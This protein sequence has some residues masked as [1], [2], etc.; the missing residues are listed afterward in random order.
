MSISQGH[1]AVSHLRILLA[2]IL[3][4]ITLF[5]LGF[6]ICASPVTTHVLSE[7]TSLFDS[8]LYDHDELVGLADATR[9][10]TVQVHFEGWQAAQDSMCKKIVKA[11]QESADPQSPKFFR[12]T[13]MEW[14]TRLSHVDTT[15]TEQCVQTISEMT[16]ISD[17]YALDD[18]AFAH[19][20]D[21]NMLIS[22]VYVV[23]LFIYGV[24]VY[25]LIRAYR[26]NK[27][28]FVQ[29]LHISSWVCLASII[30]LG[31]ACLIDFDSF[32]QTFHA[33]FFPEGNWTFSAHSL[34]ISM[35][36]SAFWMGMGIVWFITDIIA[37]I[38]MIEIAHKVDMHSTSTTHITKQ[39]RN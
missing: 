35:Y 5:T 33:I 6:L 15:N 16:K 20:H 8:S 2:C 22:R 30:V 14:I 24:T 11:A 31:V 7:K 28:A 12:W 34:L 23:L 17:A 4:T 36:P 10:L 29:I 13:A 18:A 32:F 9:D 3:C 1:A 37:C 19:L 39:G 27:H 21:C 26:T 25:E 38:V